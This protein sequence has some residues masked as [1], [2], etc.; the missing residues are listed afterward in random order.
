METARRTSLP[1]LTTAIDPRAGPTGT[2]VSILATLLDDYR[3]ALVVTK[4][5]EVVAM[6]SLD[7]PRMVAMFF[8]DHLLFSFRWGG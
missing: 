7:K 8:D 1:P 3:A 6:K 2:A 4:T 5:L